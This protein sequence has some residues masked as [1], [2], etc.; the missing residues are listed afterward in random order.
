VAA[1]GADHPAWVFWVDMDEADFE[2]LADEMRHFREATVE[3]LALLAEKLDEVVKRLDTL[4]MLLR[5]RD[6]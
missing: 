6:L 1:E 2:R 5:G 3:A 4:V